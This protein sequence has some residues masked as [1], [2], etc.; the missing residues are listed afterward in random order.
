MKYILS[1]TKLRSF[2]VNLLD[3]SHYSCDIEQNGVET[4]TH[5]IHEFIKSQ[6]QTHLY[7][8]LPNLYKAV[9]LLGDFHYV[10]SQNMRDLGTPVYSKQFFREMLITF[11]EITLHFA[12]LLS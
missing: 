10:F 1:S 2:G 6:D 11:S 4:V 3:G 12:K 8:W 7:D 5:V 9:E